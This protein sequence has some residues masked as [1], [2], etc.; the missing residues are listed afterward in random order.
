MSAT[1][2]STLDFQE[3][4]FSGKNTKVT[5]HS[6]FIKTLPTTIVYIKLDTS[7]KDLLYS[8]AY[9]FK[10]AKYSTYGCNNNNRIL[11]CTVGEH[12]IV[13]NCPENKI[14][15]VVL[16]FITH[17]ERSVLKNDQFMCRHSTKGNYKE[18]EKA[19]CDFDVYVYGKCKTFIKNCIL[20]QDANKMVNM[21]KSLES[22]IIKDR[23]TIEVKEISMKPVFETP[24]SCGDVEVKDL[25]YALK[26]LDCMVSFSNGT[27]QVYH[28]CRNC[29]CNIC[30]KYYSKELRDY[31]KSIR[32]VAGM[33]SSDATK[34]KKLL[35]DLNNLLYCYFDVKGLKLS[36]KDIEEVKK[37]ENSSLQLIKQMCK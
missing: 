2:D 34:N 9:Q 31:L 8:L 15:N 1:K 16:Q 36:Y 29:I 25:Y 4:T 22:R 17:L 19:I 12:G 20:K 23:D 26:E 32:N 5:F 11:G 33:P 24:I 14:I 27:F 28:K 13:M 35:E 30:W 37:I 6:K 18:L 21:I 10:L 7:E 3:K